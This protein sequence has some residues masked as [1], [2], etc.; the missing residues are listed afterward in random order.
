[1][2]DAE[3]LVVFRSVAAHGSIAA[4]ARE[5]GYTRSAI[6]QQMSALERTAGAA[7]LIRGGNSITITPLGRRLLEHTE[8]ILIELRAAEATLHQDRTEITGTLR[9]G[10][11]FREG[12]PIMSS[13]L[14]QIRL[15]YPQLELTLAAV[16]D[17]QGADDVRHGRLDVAI[18]SS[19]GSRPPVE[20][21]GLKQWVLGSDE[22]VLAVPATHPLAE[23]P[24]C[25][26][27][28]LTEEAWVVCQSNPLGQTTLRLCAEASYRPHIVASVNDVA[29]ALDLVRVGWG[30]TVAPQFTPATGSPDAVRRIPLEGVTARRHSMLLVRAGD[31]ELPEIAA[32]VAAVHQAA[33]STP[34]GT[35]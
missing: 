22:L 24:S 2:L 7:L 9:V 8:R 1:M 15:K 5:L 12:P 6:S 17:D 18:Q 11:A 29:T 4:A 23:R 34:L 33:Q 28:E 30:I 13:A 35:P 25:A 31:E 32:V 27:A 26:I 16:R 19:F 10:V 3:R 20:E 21:L 14:T